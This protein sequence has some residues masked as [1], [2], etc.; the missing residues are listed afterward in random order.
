MTPDEF[1]RLVAEMRA[2]QREY[3]RTRSATAL[4]QSKSLEKRVDAALREASDRPRLFGMD[5]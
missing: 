5:S 4:E 2:A 1:R 3:F